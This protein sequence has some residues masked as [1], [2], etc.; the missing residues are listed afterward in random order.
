VSIANLLETAERRTWTD[1]HGSLA[2]LRADSDIRVLIL[3][4]KVG[5]DSVPAWEEH[6]PW[7]IGTGNV[8]LFIDAAALT[9]PSAR[10]TSTVSSMVNKSRQQL[11]ELHVLVAGALVEMVAKTVNMTL[12]G[13]MRIHR[14][15]AVF[16]AALEQALVKS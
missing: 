2:F 7:L 15:R 10:M 11:S 5:D 3:E 8:R 13:F 1:E 12:G 14:D 16:E 6:Y 4:G 9:F